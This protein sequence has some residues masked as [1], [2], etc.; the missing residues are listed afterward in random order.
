MIA[1]LDDESMKFVVEG[2]SQESSAA[3]AGDSQASSS[4]AAVALTKCR[5]IQS[6]IYEHHRCRADKLA[7]RETEMKYV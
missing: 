6:M 3:V 1:M 2:D 4:A 5:L 7:G